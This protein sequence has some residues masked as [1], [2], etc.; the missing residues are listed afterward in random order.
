M[1]IKLLNN[2]IPCERWNQFN[3]CYLHQARYRIDYCN[4]IFAGLP[5]SLID[6]HL[7]CM[8]CA[9]AN[10]ISGMRKNDHFTITP[11]DELHLLPVTRQITFTS[12]LSVYKALHS[13]SSLYISKLCRQAP[14]TATIRDCSL[15]HTVTSLFHEHI[16]NSAREPLLS[17]VQL[18]R[19]IY[20]HLFQTSI[21]SL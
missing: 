19:T 1:S 16:P 20:H 11:R 9:A 17:Q 15:R 5:T 7:Q 18:P 21:I 8:L 14:A 6:D 4:T 3:W 12:C 10:I 13:I 2:T